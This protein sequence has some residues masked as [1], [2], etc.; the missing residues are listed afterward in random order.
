MKYSMKL[1]INDKIKN[2]KGIVRFFGDNNIDNK[3]LYVFLST[4]S[5]I[6]TVVSEISNG[7]K[8]INLYIDGK[9]KYNKTFNYL[10]FYIK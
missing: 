1:K 8:D 2:I 7:L 3:E 4:K 6:N 9:I 10:F 5:S